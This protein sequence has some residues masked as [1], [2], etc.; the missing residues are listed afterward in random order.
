MS[1]FRTRVVVEGGRAAS[2]YKTK[3]KWLRSDCCRIVKA[4]TRTATAK[5]IELWYSH[6]HNTLTEPD[7]SQYRVSSSHILRNCEGHL[8]LEYWIALRQSVPIAFQQCFSYCYEVGCIGLITELCFYCKVY[9]ISRATTKYTNIKF[10]RHSKAVWMKMSCYLLQKLW[11]TYQLKLYRKIDKHSKHTRFPQN[12]I[13]EAYF[14]KQIIFGTPPHSLLKLKSVTLG[15]L[16][17][18]LH[19]TAR[20]QYSVQLSNEPDFFLGVRAKNGTP[21]SVNDMKSLVAKP[22]ILALYC[23]LSCK[24]NN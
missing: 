21:A 11:K 4:V 19:Y 7:L 8:R 9:F 24:Q 2:L 14:R 20:C 12:C 10:D 23:K 18:F 1:G 15:K 17:Y 6:T 13:V 16:I 3:G 22:S 5:V